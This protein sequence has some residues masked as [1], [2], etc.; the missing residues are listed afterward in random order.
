MAAQPAS[1]P[2]PTPAPKPKPKPKPV[3]AVVVG[4][5]D[6]A[7]E[8]T[9]LPVSATKVKPTKKRR[10]F[11]S[12]ADKPNGMARCLHDF[13]G[14]TEDDLPMTAGDEVELLEEIDADWLK[15]RLNA[16]EGIF[17]REFVEII[18]P[19][20]PAAKRAETPSTILDQGS[21]LSAQPVQAAAGR[22]KCIYAFDGESH[23][24]LVIYP[25][26]MVGVHWHL[27]VLFFA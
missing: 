4:E 7:P 12:V 1:E 25:G 5:V 23:G 3:T 10:T 2:M 24:D 19:A 14:E 18:H 15:G 11:K 17:P 16:R 27:A 9:P 13:S 22:A 8:P 21:S 6:V 26:A 20:P